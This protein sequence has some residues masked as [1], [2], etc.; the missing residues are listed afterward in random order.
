MHQE[1]TGK[2]KQAKL[3]NF[4]LCVTSIENVGSISLTQLLAFNFLIF[5]L[6][7]HGTF[8]LFVMHIDMYDGIPSMIFLLICVDR[9]AKDDLEI[10]VNKQVF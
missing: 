8:Q 3:N 6:L 2:I 5:I 4:V 9:H 1:I 7:S 10:K